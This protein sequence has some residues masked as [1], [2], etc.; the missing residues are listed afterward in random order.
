MMAP[1]VAVP[2]PPIV[3]APNLSVRSPAP[4]VSAAATALHPANIN[5]GLDGTIEMSAD[6]AQYF[7]R[8]GWPKLAEWTT[9]DGV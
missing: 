5:V 8:V 1:K 6:D 3:K 4:A 7:I 9:D 2:I